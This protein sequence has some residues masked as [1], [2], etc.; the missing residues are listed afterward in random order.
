VFRRQRQTGEQ[1]RGKRLRER[2]REIDAG[3]LWASET[4]KLSPVAHFLLQG[5]TYSNKATPHNPS[6]LSQIVGL[7]D[8]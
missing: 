8:D 3:L 7:P 2:E 1:G 4:S 5:H 6:I